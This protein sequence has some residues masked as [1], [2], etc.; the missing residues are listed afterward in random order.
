M[1]AMLVGLVL[2]GTPLVAQEFSRVTMDTSWIEAQQLQDKIQYLSTKI[3]MMEAAKIRDLYDGLPNHLSENDPWPN[4]LI[5][6]ATLTQIHPNRWVLTGVI[7]SGIDNG[8]IW[9]AP[10]QVDLNLIQ[11]ETRV[12]ATFHM[13]ALGNTVTVLSLVK[14][15]GA[16]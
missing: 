16:G 1:K 8:Y 13:D 9:A 3:A 7:R 6:D 4:V 2:L 10:H 12:S 5:E 11:I 15:G 14:V